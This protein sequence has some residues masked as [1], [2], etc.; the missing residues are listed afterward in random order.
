MASKADTMY[1]EKERLTKLQQL[2]AYGINPF[3]VFGLFES[4]AK[5]I[6]PLPIKY[7]YYLQRKD[8]QMD[9]V[10]ESKSVVE[11][12]IATA[13]YVGNRVGDISKLANIHANLA[14]RSY[15]ENM[16]PMAVTFQ[17]ANSVEFHF[18]TP[19]VSDSDKI[20]FNPFK[21]HFNPTETKKS[22]KKG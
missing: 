1:S 3:A 20:A 12:Y 21:E 7:V 14:C 17:M 11:L 16:R 9:D 5:N 10:V 19:G 15:Y 22:K 18:R 8:P 6:A 13:G 2:E 4:Y